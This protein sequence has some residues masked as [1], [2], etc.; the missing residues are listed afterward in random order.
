MA[1]FSIRFLG[2]KVSHADAHAIRE[3]LLRDGHAEEDG[4]EIAVV[5]TCCVT[6]EAVRKSRHA[7][8]RAARTHRRVYVTGCGANL[9]DD[10]FAGLPENVVVVSRRSEETPGFVAGDVGA[11][12]CVQADA[13]LDRVRAFVRVQDGCS[14]SCNFCVIPLVR[15][16]S[17]SR[18]A[19]A[20]LREVAR[21]VEQ[22]HREVVLTGINLGCF[23]DRE[24]GYTLAPARPRGRRDA[25][26][27]APAA[28]VD[29][30]EPRRTTSSSARCA[31]RR[32]SRAT[33]TCRSSP[34]TTACCARWAAATPP[35]P[36]F[37]GWRRSPTST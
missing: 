28:L 2:C 4:A 9:A 14:F 8:A 26:A 12:G 34:A 13:R 11:I 23:R 10:G 19:A 37:A 30:G 3:A 20:V 32:R 35:R 24:G 33:C 7:A 21:R 27:S 31:R 16:P 17:R 5:N 22:G 29:R 15:G 1:T 36:T 25:R 18:S 6:H